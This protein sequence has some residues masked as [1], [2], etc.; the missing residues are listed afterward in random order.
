MKKSIKAKQTLSICILLSAIVFTLNSCCCEDE[1]TTRKIKKYYKEEHHE[2]TIN[3]RDNN[4]G[5][6]ILPECHSECIPAACAAASC[7][8][9]ICQEAVRDCHSIISSVAFFDSI[10]A[11]SEGPI[12]EP[13][14]FSASYIQNLLNSVSCSEKKIQLDADE[15]KKDDNSDIEIR[16]IDFMQYQK[17]NPPTDTRKTLNELEFTYQA[18]YSIALF[19]GVMQLN[20]AVFHFYKAKGKSY[21]DDCNLESSNDVIFTAED[22]NGHVLYYGDLSDYYP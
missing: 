5:D 9:P 7:T 6:L 11:F 2:H 21:D 3:H 18:Q 20:P 10:I 17:E 22:I 14:T 12:P 4:N 19:K 8:N 15:T 13:K 16:T 1:K